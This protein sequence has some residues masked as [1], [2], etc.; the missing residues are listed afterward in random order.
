[1]WISPAFKGLKQFNYFLS[2]LKKIHKD[3][4]VLVMGKKNNNENAKSE[5]Y[6]VMD[7]LYFQMDFRVH[8]KNNK[9]KFRRAFVI[10]KRH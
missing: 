10:W 5:D 4:T 6:G 3:K 1:M 2:L 7:I 8:M 9:H